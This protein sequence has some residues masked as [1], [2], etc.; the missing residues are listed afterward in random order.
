[1][2]NFNFAMGTRVHGSIISANAGIPALC[3]SGDNRSREM[4]EF[5][6]IPRFLDLPETPDRAALFEHI[7]GRIDADAMNK[8]YP[9]LFANYRDFIEKQGLPFHLDGSDV[10]ASAIPNPTIPAPNLRAKMRL[11]AARIRNGAARELAKIK[12]GKI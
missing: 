10:D 8:S 5:L 3:T 2:K 1:M 6:K 12:R 7:L 11:V 4:C 9:D